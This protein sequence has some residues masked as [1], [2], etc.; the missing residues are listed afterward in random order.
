M[1]QLHRVHQLVE[2]LHA[3]LR[4]RVR[5]AGMAAVLQRDALHLHQMQPLRRLQTE[6][7][8]GL[9]EAVLAV[10]GGSG[11]VEL[12][13]PLREH[14]VGR[15]RVHVDKLSVFLH[16]D[17]VIGG[18]AVGVRPFLQIHRRAGHQQLPAAA[19]VFH[20]AH[21]LRVVHQHMG[22]KP[23]GPRQKYPLFHLFVSHMLSPVVVF[24]T[25]FIVYHGIL[26]LKSN[27]IRSCP[28]RQL[29]Q[30]IFRHSYKF[31]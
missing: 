14:L 29:I 30:K 26:F 7:Q 19:R 21:R 5:K 15:L 17:Q 9:S 3:P 22:D 16:G 13:R 23:V 20:V 6:I 28:K 11:G 8:P 24:F 10:D 31:C 27:F 12:Q 1:P 18:L 4:R 25:Y 2:M